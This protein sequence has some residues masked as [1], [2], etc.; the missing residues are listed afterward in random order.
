MMISINI[1]LKAYLNSQ[2]SIPELWEFKIVIWCPSSNKQ[3]TT[4]ACF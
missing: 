1:M 2:H 3:P 4:M